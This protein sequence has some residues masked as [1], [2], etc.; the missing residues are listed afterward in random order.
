MITAKEANTLTTKAIKAN[1]EK[2]SSEV[3]KV[4]E[5]IEAAVKERASLGFYY[6]QLS[7]NTSEVSSTIV[8]VV[9]DTL[10]KAGYLV[11][12]CT[13]TPGRRTYAIEWNIPSA[14]TKK[15]ITEKAE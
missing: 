5:S 9:V 3:K 12:L 14:V 8:Q 6:Y 11:Y 2:E 4:L 1:K 10:K 7:F 13:M 15:S